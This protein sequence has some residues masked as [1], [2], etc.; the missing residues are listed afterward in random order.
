MQKNPLRAFNKKYDAAF[1]ELEQT[2]ELIKEAVA[3]KDQKQH[4]LQDWAKQHEV[5]QAWL[6]APQTRQMQ[7]VA[8]ALK[9]PHLKERVNQIRHKLQQQQQ[10][11]PE[12][13]TRQQQPRRGRERGQDLSL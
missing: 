6:N 11:Q 10:V 8:E 5:Y 3:Q 12:L 9:V 1:T 13:K 7:E 2:M 4:Q